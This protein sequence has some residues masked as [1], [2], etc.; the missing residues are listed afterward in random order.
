MDNIGTYIDNITSVYNSAT[1]SEV[2]NGKN[3][4]RNA[5]QYA[6]ELSSL[7]NVPIETAAAVIAAISPNCSW[8]VNKLCGVAGRAHKKA[9]FSGK[10]KGLRELKSLNPNRKKDI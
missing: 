2:K 10:R 8:E 3:W 5:N 6:K 1:T 7:H 9:N 4:Y